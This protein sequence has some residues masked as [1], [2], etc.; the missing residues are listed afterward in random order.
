MLAMTLDRRL[1]FVEEDAGEL[2]RILVLET[3]THEL[4]RRDRLQPLPPR[5]G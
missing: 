3:F 4:S 5:R 2:A 1:V